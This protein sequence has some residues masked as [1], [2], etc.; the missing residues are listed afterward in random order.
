MS[1]N[2]WVI[3]ITATAF[4]FVAGFAYEESKKTVTLDSN[5]I[6]EEISTHAK[7]V[8]EL[9]AEQQINVKAADDLSH[10]KESKLKDRMTIVWKEAHKIELSIDGKTNKVWTTADTVQ[11]LLKQENLFLGKHDE[12]KPDYSAPLKNGTKVTINKAFLLTLDDG[13]KK[14][15]V[16][17]TSITVADFLNK[18][19]LTVGPLDILSLKQDRVLQPNDYF[20]ITR[21]E[22]VTDV[23]EE[24]KPFPVVERKDSTMPKGKEKIIKAGKEG[25]ASKRYEITRKNGQEVSRKL[26]AETT[27]KE[28]EEQIVAVG[29]KEESSVAAA[30]PGPG[31][32]LVVTSTAYTAHCSGCSGITATGLNLIA[33]PGMKVIAV[34]P[35]IIPLGS[36]VYVEG[37]GYAVAGDTGG[38]IKGHKI[39]VFIPSQS[40]AKSWGRKQVRIKV[41]N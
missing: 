27:L 38:A 33:N 17:T 12:I 28:S 34:D 5:G 18:Q 25:L 21:I 41:L 36:K 26:L 35:S 39:D 40:G 8:E 22:K 13:G 11:T 32:E 20:A 1:K 7:T 19:N 16:W 2:K 15:P 30:A 29:T 23:V 37:Y 6:Q 10:S 4:L 14:R 3:L 31:R 9:L 24:P